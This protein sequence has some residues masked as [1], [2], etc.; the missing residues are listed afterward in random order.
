MKSDPV[1]R[2]V[3]GALGND[4]YH[5]G[6]GWSGNEPG[7]R[8]TIGDSTEL[9]L[10]NPGSGTDLILELDVSPF[11]MPPALPVQRLRVRI[12]DTLVGEV[13]LTG[14]GKVGFQVPAS[15]F[16]APGPVRLIFDHPDAARPVDLDQG[17]DV[18]PLAVSFISLVLL[19]VVGQAISGRAEPI[20]GI[21]AADIGRLTGIPAVQ[22]MQGFESLGDNCEFGL[23]QRRCGAEPLGLLRF[24]NLELRPE[25]LGLESG[26][27]AIGDLDEMEFWL[28]DGSKREYVVRDRRHALVFHTSFTKARSR[29]TNCSNGSRKGFSSFAANLSR[30]Y[31]TPRRYS[32]VS[33]T[34]R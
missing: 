15:S 1:T 34:S 31:K 6:S 2:I 8:W 32:F 33:E 19:P 29:R 20:P 16:A 17:T 14:P 26:F 7:Y 4:T 27:D 23:L 28:S 21:T 12:R 25:L 24:A 9:W 13:S 3:F 18:R 11:V 10:E 5:L 22:F 30:I